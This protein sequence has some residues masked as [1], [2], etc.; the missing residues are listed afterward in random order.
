MTTRKKAVSK[1]KTVTK[2]SAKAKTSTSKPRAVSKKPAERR[3]SVRKPYASPLGLDV[4]LL[5]QSFKILEPNGKKLVKRFYQLLFE[6][7]PGVKP[8]FSATT[9]AKQE[10]KL[11]SALK[12]VIKNLRDPDTLVGVL[13]ML[14][15]K[16]ASYGALPEH[17]AA[18]ASTLMD[19]L[20]EFTGDV[21]TEKM[22]DAWS[23]ALETIAATML[24]A[25]DDAEETQMVANRKDVATQVESDEL[26]RL[27]AAIDGSMTAVMMVDRDFVVTYV[28]A[29]TKSLLTKNAAALS[30]AFI[31]FDPDAIV[32]SCIDQFH[33]NPAH[34]RKLLDNPNNLPYQTDISV[35]HLKFSLNVTAQVD[36]DGN[37]IGNTLEWQDVTEQRAKELEVARLQSAVDGA[38]ANLMLCDEDLNITYANPAVVSMLVKRQSELA[39]IFPGFNARNLVGQNIDI[40]HKNPAHQ[41]GLLSD[42][43]RLPAKA[44]IAVGDLEFQVNAT[45]VTDKNGDYMGNMV[46]WRDI[47]EQKS[48]ERQIQKLIE[49]AVNGELDERI[50]SDEFDGFLRGLGD[51]INQLMDAVVEPIRESK[52]VATALSDGDLTQKMDGDYNGEFSE[53]HD[54]LNLSVNN[55]YDMVAKIQDGSASIATSAGEIAQ[56]NTDLSQRT[57]EQASSLEETASSMEELTSTVSQNADNARQANQLATGA[58]DQAAKGGEVV[59]NAVSAMA[60][61]N[62]SSKKIADII[63]VIDEIAFQTN[64]LALNAA[65]EAARAGEQGRGFAVVAA[66]V[67]NLAQR[68]AAAAKEIKTLIND[69]VEKV[70]EG[71]KLVDQSDTT[72]EEIVESIKKISDIVAEIASA[73]QEQASGIEQINKAITQMD[74]VVQQNAALVEE[75]AASSE[76]LDEQA[77]NLDEM[78]TFFSI[79]DD[80]SKRGSNKKQNS[81]RPKTT[82]KSKPVS[83]RSSRPSA[84]N[85]SASSDS[86]WEEF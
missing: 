63:G 60:E 59:G 64:L 35:G 29:S 81:S 44:E 17:Y 9:V 25:Y 56:G 57:E 7:Y 5:E 48:A 21:W 8:M 37:Y 65:V 83:R 45:G 41:R 34:Q 58:R 55:L 30:Q 14:G 10:T 23:A 43:S 6:R 84:S 22:H 76:S 51:Q 13:T 73:S 47:T 12:L 82:N 85:N 49:A 1:T 80:N 69:S 77:N 38:Q 72:L 31:G 36:S 11:L 39:Q 18:V 20:K 16:H 28:N 79:G 24:K 46:E 74:E 62:S 33:K 26:V 4:Q 52:R 42:L 27:R 2:K 66:E 70:E 50:N 61:I 71:T 32:G 86:E 40:F 75:A 68:S 67:R 3:K 19:V 53:L 54:A 15:E 78:M